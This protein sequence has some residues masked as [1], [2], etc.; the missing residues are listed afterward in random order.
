MNGTIYLAATLNIISAA[1]RS[2]LELKLQN[3]TAIVK[4]TSSEITYLFVQNLD[5]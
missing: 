3:G 5:Q 1:E 4:K 2:G